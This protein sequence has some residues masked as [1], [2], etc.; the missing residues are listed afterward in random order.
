MGELHLVLLFEYV[1]LISELVLGV[2]ECGFQPFVLEDLI[3]Q[4]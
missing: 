3:A 4:L 2:V 1:C